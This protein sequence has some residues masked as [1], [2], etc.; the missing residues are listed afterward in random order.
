MGKYE[1]EKMV[2][3]E[4]V[5]AKSCTKKERDTAEGWDTWEELLAISRWEIEEDSEPLPT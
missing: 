3:E 5:C 4:A 2:D 1:V